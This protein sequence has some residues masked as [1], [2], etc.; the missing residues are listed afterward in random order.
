MGEITQTNTR[1]HVHEKQR[2][3]QA[4]E[5]HAI[6]VKSARHAENHTQGAFGGRGGARDKG[7]LWVINCC[8]I[9]L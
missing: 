1:T 2:A 7:K 9:K 3:T 4:S 8:I 6:R 5:V